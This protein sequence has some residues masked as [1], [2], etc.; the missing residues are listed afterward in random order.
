M[1]HLSTLKIISLGL[2]LVFA[3]PMLSIALPA[4]A[5]NG[6]MAGGCHG[7]HSPLPMQNHTCCYATPTSPV[8]VQM[9][10]RIATQPLVVAS[11]VAPNVDRTALVYVDSRFTDVS[12]PLQQVLRI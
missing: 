10:P 6:G 5:S 11:E 2:V 8:R 1:N 4:I 7:H 9:A 3:A 12:P